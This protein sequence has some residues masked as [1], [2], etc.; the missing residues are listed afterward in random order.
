MRWMRW[1][2]WTAF[3]LFLAALFG[4]QGYALFVEEP[5]PSQHLPPARDVH[6]SREANGQCPLTQSFGLHADGFSAIEIYPR[7][8]VYPP[9]RPMRVRIMDGRTNTFTLLLEKTYDTAT[10]DLNA[11][12]RIEVPRVDD[13]AGRLFMLEVTM[14]AA[15]G[16]GVRFEQ[17]GAGYPEGE[18]YIECVKDWGDLK[19]RTEV[20]R[21][22]IFS[23]VQHLRRSL[24]APL[25]SDAVLLAILLIGNV[26]LAMVV[27]AL[28]FAPSESEAAPESEPAPE[29]GPDYRP[30]GNAETTAAQPRV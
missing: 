21:A 13:S 4:Y 30:N 22:T 27:Y 10:L 23:N 16:H 14:L 5:D 12:L 3:V 1:L 20:Q 18:L 24:P 9:T 17:G 19:F 28:A 7:Q 15:P 11:P 2:R 8:S 6:L 29:S 26:A 25:R